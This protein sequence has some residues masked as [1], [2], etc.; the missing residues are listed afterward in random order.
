[1]K[2][3]DEIPPSYL[4]FIT[5]SVLALAVSVWG[6]QQFGV[7]DLSGIMGSRTVSTSDNI[8]FSQASPKVTEEQITAYLQSKAGERLKDKGNAFYTLGSRYNIDPAF[9]VAVSRI[10]TSLGKNTCGSIPQSC[11]N[12]FC[13]SYDAVRFTGLSNGACGSSR[14][15]SFESPEKCIEAFFKYIREKY[16]IA[17]PP[18]DTIS[19]VSC[20][21]DSGFDSHCY[22][23]GEHT[24]YCPNWVSNVPLFV[25]EIRNYDAS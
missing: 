21:P 16:A 25:S 19:K 12:F 4:F 24:P 23:V 3:S 14:W 13:M 2:A 18:Q 22:C 9:G 17:V 5:F 7:L 15:A 20:A 10:E 8:L 1:M 6:M 11:N